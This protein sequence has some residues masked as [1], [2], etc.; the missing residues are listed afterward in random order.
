MLSRVYTY[1]YISTYVCVY[2]SDACSPPPVK[3]REPL[4]SPPSEERI[5]IL[6]PRYR[7]IRTQ[8][9][10]HDYEAQQVSSQ[11]SAHAQAKFEQKQKASQVKSDEEACAAARK[12]AELEQTVAS[13]S[14]RR[15]LVVPW[16]LL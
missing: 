12:I 2:V 4:P 3:N 5:T 1:V 6:S 15:Q 7:A 11:A 10:K 16:C 14:Q 8:R 9:N 13:D